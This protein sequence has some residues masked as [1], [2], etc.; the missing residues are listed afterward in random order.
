MI[1][2]QGFVRGAVP[3]GLLGLL[4]CV[5]VMAAG[6]ED[7]A[8]KI[9]NF[10]LQRVTVKAGTTAT[11]MN[12]GDIPHAIAS[13]TKAFR[14][15]A[16]DTEYDTGVVCDTQKQAE[17]LAMLLDDNERTAIATVNAE[18]RDP[19][20]CAVETVAFVRGARLATARSRA[21]TF[22]VVEILIV[23]ADL[24]S[25]FQSIAPG[26]HFMLVKIDERNA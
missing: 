10:A 13:T 16:L 18:E 6:P 20:A 15:K 3:G 9:K 7:I 21:D 26:A 2:R 22:A 19:S 11:W 1:M 24:G 5:A 14:S 12:A 8:A 25:G 4:A 17:R 23:G